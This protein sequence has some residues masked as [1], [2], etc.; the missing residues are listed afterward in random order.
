MLLGLDFIRVGFFTPCLGGVLGFGNS[1]CM[2]IR[3]EV[4]R[5]R[6]FYGGYE[7]SLVFFEKLYLGLNFWDLNLNF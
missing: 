4:S 5:R 1:F 2:D 7:A 6:V 3:C